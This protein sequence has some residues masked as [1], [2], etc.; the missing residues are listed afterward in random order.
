MPVTIAMDVEYVKHFLSALA[1]WRAIMGLIAFV[2]TRPVGADEWKSPVRPFAVRLCY[3]NGVSVTPFLA[4]TTRSTIGSTIQLRH[5]GRVFSDTT[6]TG[7]GK[8]C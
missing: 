3:T 6:H 1:A 5:S 2:A 4:N 8:R 7:Y